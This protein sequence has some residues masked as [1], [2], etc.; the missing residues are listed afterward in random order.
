MTN[1][2]PALSRSYIGPF[3][4]SRIWA[5][6]SLRDDDVIITT[7]PKCGTTWMQSLVLTLIF[8]ETGM[9]LEIDHISPW[10][11]P[12]FRDQAEIS[13]R[14]TG[15]TH[16]RCIKTHTP[17]DG[18]SYSPSCTYIAVYRHPMDALFSMRRHVEN[19]KLKDD[20]IDQHYPEDIQKSFDNFLNNEDIQFGTDLISV[21]SIAN[22]YQSV[23]QWSELPN[24]H[25]F[26]Y[27]DMSQ[28]LAHEIDRLSEILDYDFSSDQI[29][30]F[31]DANSFNTM[32]SN[33][34]RQATSGG[35]VTFKDEVEFFSSGTSNKWEQYLSA[36]DI[37]SYHIRVG[38]LL[39]AEEITW[40]EWGSTR[41]GTA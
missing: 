38:Q 31:A 23:A 28:D 13:N 19:L 1:A 27:A 6:F 26:H 34:A 36:E 11:D 4:D 10:L 15:Q 41:T 33:A 8:G 20:H 18:I 35:S 5:D 25:L 9:D 17:F 21:G 22:H 12:G 2:Q 40:L 29:N 7:P 16:R 37:D 39:P 30:D 3:T 24:I 32:K 14:Y